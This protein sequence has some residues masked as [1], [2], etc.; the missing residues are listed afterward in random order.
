MRTRIRRLVLGLLAAAVTTGC[1]AISRPPADLASLQSEAVTLAA[2]DR[3]LRD[4]VIARL[5]RRAQRRSDRT[6]DI[7]LLSGGGQNGAFGVGF[8]RGWRTRTDTPMPTFDMV[9]GISTGALQAPY[10]LLG[11]EASLDTVS[12]LY[13]R[14]ATSIAPTFDWWF[15]FR[16]T[17]GL[18]NTGRFDRTLE[19][20][21]DGDF[22]TELRAAFANDQ[23]LLFGTT[24][25]DLGIGQLWSLGDELDTTEQGL[26]RA[27]S[28]L[29]AATAIPA[30]F[31]P[32]VIDG[33]VHA[34]GGVV[35][36]LLPVLTLA[37]YHLLGRE[38]SAQGM[39]DVT[40][41]LWVVM[42]VW[43]H[44]EPRAIKP[45]SRGTMDSR[46]TALLFYLHQPATFERLDYLA[47]A[48]RAEVPG[49]NL[50]LR[51][52]ALPASESVAPG[53]NKLFEK[54]FMQRL[55]SLG[56]AK[57]RSSAPW[58]SVSTAFVRPEI[59]NKK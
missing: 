27:R 39:R 42:N 52:A 25:F 33:H 49:L 23:Q 17:G 2:R 1:A 41:R 44:A 21:I 38:L 8:L 57:A 11:T 4:T 35:E 43:S 34:D 3:A 20:A 53:A 13:A 51:I 26:R 28:L 29:K 10:A 50:Q 15:W 22:R 19:E 6:L 58:D 46:S 5:V 36:N 14:A 16:R 55:D 48:V 47:R 30:I 7:L 45:S 54:R 56:F 32:V 18:V 24:D 12:A 31:P 9:T 59:R 37:D 40:V